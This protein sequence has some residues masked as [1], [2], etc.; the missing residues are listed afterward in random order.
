MKITNKVPSC[1]SLVRICSNFMYKFTYIRIDTHTH[2][3]ILN[4]VGISSV[5]F[6]FYEIDFDGLS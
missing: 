5:L 4:N 1:H 3:H 6:L 2:T